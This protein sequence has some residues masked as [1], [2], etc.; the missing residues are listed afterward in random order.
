L[1]E[2]LR[3][4]SARYWLELGEADEAL[5]ELEALPSGA[6]NHPAAAKVRLAALLALGP[7]NEMT[8]QE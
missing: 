3:I 5:R 6:W 7:K 1:D 4:K 2:A 8:V